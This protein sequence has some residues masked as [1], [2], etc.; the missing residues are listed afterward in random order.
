MISLAKL[1]INGNQGKPHIAAHADNVVWE[2]I[3]IALG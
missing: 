3:I 1:A 2:W